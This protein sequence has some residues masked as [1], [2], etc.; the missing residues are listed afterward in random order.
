MVSLKAVQGPT[1]KIAPQDWMTAPATKV[2]I[3]ALTAK[4][5]EVRF[6]G[7]C[8]RD[9]LA[10]RPVKD[11]DLATPDDPETVTRLLEA[12]GIKVI[13]TGITHG[14]VTAV[15]GDDKFEVTTLRR[16][17]ETDGR[18]A[19]VAFTDDWMADAERRDFTINALSAT[20]AGDVF[21][22]HDG[23][24]D[25][26]HGRIR[27]VGR[28]RER[29][30]EDVLRILRFF[31]F[32]GSHG[33]PPA[34]PDAVDACRA[35]APKLVQLSG[36][37]VRDE[38]FKILMTPNPAEVAVMMKGLGVFAPILPEAGD[39]GR[40]RMLTWL[41][42]RAIRIDSVKPDPLRRL[43]ALVA[44]DA[45]GA[46][47]IAERLRFSNRQALD[48]SV[49]AAPPADIKPD[50]TEADLR[51]ALHRLGSDRVRDLTLL[52]WAGEI[53]VTPRIPAARTQKWI[54]VL[55]ACDGWRD[56]TFPLKGADALAL[57][58]P[59]GPRVGELLA[60]VEAWWEDGDFRAGRAECLERM[61]SLL[62]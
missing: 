6:V 53:A 9:A 51:G 44:T 54:A 60:E 46:A 3:A 20:P 5:A 33:R 30:A 24:G 26:A 58:I 7:G 55:E 29:I 16:D 12:A 32:F 17:V 61:R 25:L 28:A 45:A 41:E 4:G 43:A 38:L 10:H 27:F 35:E 15:V 37:R 21:D 48:F 50:M 52:A 56:V 36:E 18:H 22:L 23:I 31:R 2:V 34:D 13:P 8:V 11:V 39:V 62:A 14:S 47:A 19:K 40:L 49:L 59:A 42:T 1:G 57:G